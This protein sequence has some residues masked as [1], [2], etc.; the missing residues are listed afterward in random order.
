M[1]DHLALEKNAF[2]PALVKPID[3]NVGVDDNPL[4]AI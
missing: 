1:L 4:H 2:M 3:V